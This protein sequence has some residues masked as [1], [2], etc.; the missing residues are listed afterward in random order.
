MQE[1]EKEGC[2]FMTK[3]HVYYQEPNRVASQICI[4]TVQDYVKTA[5][6]GTGRGGGGGVGV[7][8]GWG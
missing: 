6:G 8:V 2:W 3:G 4:S 5:G 7:G 1:R